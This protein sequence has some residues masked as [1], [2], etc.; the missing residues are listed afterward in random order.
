MW[1]QDIVLWN[2]VWN[3]Y[4]QFCAL[5][6]H[7]S[8]EFYPCCRCSRSTSLIVSLSVW[9]NH[10]NNTPQGLV[11][12]T[13]SDIVYGPPEQSHTC[14]PHDHGQASRCRGCVQEWIRDGN[15]MAEQQILQGY[16]PHNHC[17]GSWE[18]K[19]ANGSPHCIT[20]LTTVT[21]TLQLCL[22]SPQVLRRQ[23]T[24]F[25]YTFRIQLWNSVTISD[26]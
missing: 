21:A 1:N 6:L 4:L 23:D 14:V 12:C 11:T 8:N 24:V 5:P 10:S 9:Q 25:L 20:T 17:E 7:M 2:I 26:Y 3:A 16:S 13:A 15:W 19:H 18:P 22:H